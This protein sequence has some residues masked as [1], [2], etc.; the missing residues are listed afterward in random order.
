[1]K[2]ID[3]E[4]ERDKENSKIRVLINYLYKKFKE[5]NEAKIEYYS[6]SKEKFIN[7]CDEKDW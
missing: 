2:K 6:F 4:S 3:Q 1:M 5:K 7:L